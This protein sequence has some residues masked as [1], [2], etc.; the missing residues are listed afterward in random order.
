MLGSA[1]ILRKSLDGPNLQPILVIHVIAVY[2]ID[3]VVI[4]IIII[5][6]T[7]GRA[8]A[9]L[10]DLDGGDSMLV[11]ILD[12]RRGEEEIESGIIVCEGR[13]DTLEEM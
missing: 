3:I 5:V 7:L 2:D 6:T 1:F 11:G 10:L 12:C 13:D 8:S 9:C 4:V